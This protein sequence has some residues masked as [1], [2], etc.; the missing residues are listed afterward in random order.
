M[1]TYPRLIYLHVGTIDLQ[2]YIIFYLIER[3]YNSIQ[4]SIIK[5]SVLHISNDFIMNNLFKVNKM[6]LRGHM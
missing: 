2:L 3:L 4:N 6:G 5:C 1:S